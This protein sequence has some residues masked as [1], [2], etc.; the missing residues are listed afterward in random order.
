M[1][2][3]KFRTLI[4]IAALCG[5]VA[6]SAM[7]DDDPDAFQ[8]AALNDHPVTPVLEG[9]NGVFFRVFLDLRMNHPFTD[10]TVDLLG[11]LADALREN[12]TEL[13]FLPVPTKSLVLNDDLPKQASL[14]GYDI[15]TATQVYRNIIERLRDRGVVAIDG[16]EAMQDGNP[17]ALPFF[18]ADFH[19]TAEG[20]RRAAQG[21]AAEMDRLNLF[22]GMERGEYETTPLQEEIAFSGLRR[23]IQKKC[24]VALPEPVTM[25]YQTEAVG[26]SDADA[27]VD[28]FGTASS[29]DLAL[30]GTSFSDMEISHFEGWL[31]QYTGLEVVNY[32]ITGGNQFGAMLSYLT[33]QDFRENRPK[34]LVWE[35]P[36]YNNLM[37]NGDQPLR[38][39]VAAAGETCTLELPSEL[40]DRNTLTADLSGI[41]LEAS[42]V[43]H[44]SAAGEGS[45]EV[46]FRFETSS[47]AVRHKAL[48][49]ENRLRATGNYY[50]PINSLGTVDFTK[51]SVTFDRTLPKTASLRLCR[52]QKEN[53]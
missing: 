4:S 51:L 53:L 10:Q 52:S 41:A 36:L 6:T 18:Q 32:A 28:L 33:S 35:N 14:Y 1:V 16:Q 46:E 43:I 34:F 11:Q 13:V 12:G 5:G 21:V 27:A 2:S 29:I 39:M 15:E 25:T 38:E 50:M 47:G 45:R 7:A 30:V 31:K 40:S 17:D 49:R 24:K 23:Q 42:D 20:A 48:R 26:G 22:A 37:Q 44:A 3:R 8:C 19:W 9:H